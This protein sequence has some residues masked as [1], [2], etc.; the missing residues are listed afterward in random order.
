MI[1]ILSIL[2]IIACFSAPF[3]LIDKIIKKIEDLYAEFKSIKDFAY[4]KLAEEEKKR[5]LI[6]PLIFLY[7]VSK[8][9]NSTIRIRVSTSR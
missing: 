3:I 4:K 5:T 8:H 2:V 6:S 7:L 9:Y 1:I